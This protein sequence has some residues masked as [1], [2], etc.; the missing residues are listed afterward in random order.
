L[1]EYPFSAAPVFEGV[2][3]FKPVSKKKVNGRGKDLPLK[4]Q[5]NVK[6]EKTCS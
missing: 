3:I 1:K 6:E 5:A 4:L 2:V